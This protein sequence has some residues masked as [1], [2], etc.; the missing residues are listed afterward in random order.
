MAATN[1]AGSHLSARERF[2]SVPLIEN[3]EWV[4]VDKRDSWVPLRPPPGDERSSWGSRR[5][6][7]IESFTARLERDADWVKVFERSD[8]VVFRRSAPEPDRM[9]LRRPRSP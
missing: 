5:P 4:V 3:A 7:L 6:K 9:G 1:T 2:F 8:I